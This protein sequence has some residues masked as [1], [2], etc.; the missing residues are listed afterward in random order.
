[1]GDITIN[2]AGSNHSQPVMQGNLTIK[3]TNSPQTRMSAVRKTESRVKKPLHYNH[4]EISGQLVRAK[5]A[6]SAGTVLTRAKARLATL[7][8]AAGSGQYDEREV[9]NAIAHARRMVRCA[10][11]KVRNLREE[12]REQGAHKKSSGNEQQRHRNEVKRRVAQKERQLKSKIAAEELQNVQQEKGRRQEMVKKRRQHRSEEQNKIT[13]ADMKYLKG[14][15]ENNHQAGNTGGSFDGGVF[16]ELSAS[17]QA[18]A[19]AQMMQQQTEAQIEAEIE[20]EMA[21]ELGGTT[22]LSDAGAGSAAVGMTGSTSTGAVGV[23][24]SG[25]MDVSV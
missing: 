25:G 7:Q 4:R 9:E 20:A 21:V 15:M 23:D 10:Q 18:L 22:E 5:R 13:E 11:L 19:E 2:G 3:N 24:V 17:A 1:M 6:Q 14:M 8:R 12:E 16:V